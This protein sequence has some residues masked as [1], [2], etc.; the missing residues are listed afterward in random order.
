MTVRMEYIQ[1][2]SDAEAG[3]GNGYQEL[4]GPAASPRV[5]L[6]FRMPLWRCS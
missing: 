4:R 5:L 3:Q 2:G 6:E 1:A